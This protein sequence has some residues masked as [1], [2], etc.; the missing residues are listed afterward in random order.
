MRTPLNS[1]SPRKMTKLNHCHIHSG[2]FTFGPLSGVCHKGEVEPVRLCLFRPWFYI[3]GFQDRHI[4]S[5]MIL[6]L[7]KVS[8]GFGAAREFTRCFDT[9]T[10]SRR[11]HEAFS[12]H[13]CLPDAA[14]FYCF[15]RRCRS[16]EVTLDLL[17]A[18]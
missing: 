16:L 4:V 7:H 13:F 15:S 8:M 12:R 2:R 18:N 11:H 10:T 14:L 6:S 3:S 5:C 1:V 9:S 17:R